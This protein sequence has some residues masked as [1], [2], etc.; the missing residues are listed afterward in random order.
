M[1]ATG[2]L[3]FGRT[4]MAMIP[5]MA[6][7]A[8]ADLRALESA[9]DRARSALGCAYASGEEFHADMVRLGRDR[10]VFGRRR[11]ARMQMALGFT[12]LACLVCFAVLLRF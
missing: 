4:I 8:Q 11:M 5:I 2:C 1:P 9:I 7:Q 10:G 12:T 3:P 6:V